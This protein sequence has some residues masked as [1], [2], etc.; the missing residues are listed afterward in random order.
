[1][2]YIFHSHQHPDSL[3]AAYKL[4]EPVKSNVVLNNVILA[5]SDALGKPPWPAVGDY[6]R[7]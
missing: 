5:E 4:P 1:M 6:I 7:S 3:F 2:L